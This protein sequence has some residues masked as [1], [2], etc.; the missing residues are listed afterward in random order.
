MAAVEPDPP[1]DEGDFVLPRALEQVVQGLYRRVIE[2]SE[3]QLAR[4]VDIAPSEYA[5]A[6]LHLRVA[7]MAESA[8]KD[9]RALI[10]AYAHAVAEPR[11]SLQGVAAAQGVTPSNLRRRYKPVHVAA[12]RELLAERPVVDVVQFAFPSVTDEQLVGL[13]GALDNDLALRGRIRVAEYDYSVKIFTGVVGAERA[14]EL[15]ESNTSALVKEWYGASGVAARDIN[16]RPLSM[17]QGPSLEG[18]TAELG[19]EYTAYLT[20]ELDAFGVFRR[21]LN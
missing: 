17:L 8:L 13:S 2:K 11:P 6:T 12:V 19:P 10:N 7:T 5:N 14:Q 21:G 15:A 4:P 1:E 16:N 18:A 20:R 9:I 3:V